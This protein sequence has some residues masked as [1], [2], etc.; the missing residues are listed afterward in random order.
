MQIPASLERLVEEGAEARLEDDGLEEVGREA[1]DGHAV[2]RL[3]EHVRGDGTH[4]EAAIEQL[5]LHEVDLV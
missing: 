3:D 5:L 1:D 2:E 4:G